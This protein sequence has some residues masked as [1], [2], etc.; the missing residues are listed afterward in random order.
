MTMKL[1]RTDQHLDTTEQKASFGDDEVAYLK[2]RK[3]LETIINKSFRNNISRH[4]NQK[5]TRDVSEHLARVPL[6]PGPVSFPDEMFADD[7]SQFIAARMAKILKDDPKLVKKLVPDFPVGC[8]RLGPAEGFL[9]AFHKDNVELGE[10]DIEAFTENGL[11][12]RDGREYTADV[13]ICATGFDVSFKPQFP[14]IGREGLS[15]KEA[16][17]DDPAA[18]LALAAHGFP[19]FMS[20]KMGLLPQ[21]LFR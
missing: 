9:E 3:E 2:H 21:G 15:L 14:V 12:T 7:L 10:G 17:K 13:I 19:N 1:N 18:Y 11:R 5:M 16:W 8:R 20:K 6:E 4:P